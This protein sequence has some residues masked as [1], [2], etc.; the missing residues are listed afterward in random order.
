MS[1]DLKTELAII[2]ERH[3]TNGDGELGQVCHFDH[4]PTPLDC[5]C[6]HGHNRHIGKPGNASCMSYIYWPD[7]SCTAFVPSPGSVRTLWESH[8]HLV[9]T[10]KAIVELADQWERNAHR[11]CDGADH[12]GTCADCVGSD[13]ADLLRAKLAQLTGE[14]R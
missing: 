2:K 8:A 9:T 1:E 6:G 7:C 10:L 3:H 5:T 14:N 11:A 12:G 13:Y 4:Y